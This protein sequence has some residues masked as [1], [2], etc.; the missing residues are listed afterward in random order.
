MHWGKF[1]RHNLLIFCR[2]FIRGLPVCTC[3]TPTVLISR[4][5]AWHVCAAYCLTGGCASPCLHGRRAHVHACVNWE[6]G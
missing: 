3:L 6:F 1:R 2:L 5:G 4:P